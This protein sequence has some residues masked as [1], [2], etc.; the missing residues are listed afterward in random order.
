MPVT[1][2]T[3]ESGFSL[4]TEPP[5]STQWCNVEKIV[6]FKRDLFAVDLI[7]V[8]FHLDDHFIV[9]IDEEMIGYS[10]FLNVLETR[11]ELAPDWWS[12]VAFPAFEANMTTIWTAT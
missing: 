2:T 3:D 4:D 11:F 10:E 1:I 7:C 12:N 9:E 5:I 6:A 8:A